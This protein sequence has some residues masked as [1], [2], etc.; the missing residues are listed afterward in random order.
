MKGI[1]LMK[2]RVSRKVNKRKR[3]V[4]YIDLDKTYREV[5]A[6][7]DRITALYNRDIKGNNASKRKR[8][9]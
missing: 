6:V 7:H 1:D 4:H 5:M 9:G 8:K 2:A 3:P